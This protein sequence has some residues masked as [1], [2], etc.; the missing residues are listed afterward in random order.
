MVATYEV[1]PIT[2]LLPKA[3]LTKPRKCL[4]PELSNE[5]KGVTTQIK[6]LNEY[7]LMAVFTLLLNRV[8][9]F[10]NFMSNLDRETCQ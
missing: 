1:E 9:D 3:N 7:F 8:H 10:T 5:P 4:N 2:I 6:A